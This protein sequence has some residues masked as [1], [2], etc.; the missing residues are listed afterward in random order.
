M[1]WTPSQYTKLSQRERAF[2][3]ASVQLKLEEEKKQQRKMKA[4]SSKGRRR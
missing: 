4:D 2:I 3:I 1:G